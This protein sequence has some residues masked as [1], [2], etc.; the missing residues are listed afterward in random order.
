MRQDLGGDQVVLKFQAL[1][2]KPAVT[3]RPEHSRSGV[4]DQPAWGWSGRDERLAIDTMEDRPLVG[5]TDWQQHAL[6]LEG[7]ASCSYAQ[8]IGR[9]VLDPAVTGTSRP[10]SWRPAWIQ[11]LPLARQAGTE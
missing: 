8:A 11:Q 7:V 6:V 5:T 9:H 1:M 10:T 3:G 2:G 4:L